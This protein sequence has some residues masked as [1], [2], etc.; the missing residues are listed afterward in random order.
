MFETIQ[1]ING[2]GMTIFLVEQNAHVALGIAD[3]GYVLQTGGIVMSDRADTLLADPRLS[4]A[5]L[6]EFKEE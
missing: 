6:G 3:R 1:E 5:Y 2:Q 4:Q